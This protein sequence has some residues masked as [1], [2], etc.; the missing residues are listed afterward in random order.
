MT[1]KPLS[2]LKVL[3]L[4]SVLAGPAVGMFLAELGAEVTKVENPNT[5]GDVTRSWKLTTEDPN[6]DISAYFASVNFGKQHRF[7]DLKKDS[8]L[9]EVKKLA[10]DADIIIANYRAGQ[11]E[12]FGLDFASLK[13]VNP[14]LIYGNITGF[15]AEESR[16]AFD[17]VL[18]A[19]T[20]YMF[21]NGEPENE[22][23]K[24]PVALIDVLAAHQLKEAILLALLQREKTGNGAFVEVSLFD[25]AVSALTNQASNWLM[26]GHIPQ[27]MGSLHP[28]IAPYGEILNS[29]D[30]KQIVLAVGSNAQFTSLCEVLGLEKLAADQRFATNQHRVENRMQL[31]QELQQKASAMNCEVL[32]DSFLEKNIPAG[33]I[34]NLK[35]VFASEAAQALV[36]KDGETERVSQI[37][38]KM[39]S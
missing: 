16:P 39:R 17:V 13:K 24:M 8:E 31:Q 14:K 10:S 1:S 12:A 7:L 26:K 2:G 19:E 11:A 35:E 38:F 4:A 23:T 36:R 29:Q 32:M 22:P 34:R 21:M 28:N 20:G 33:V 27:R 25:A 37:A 30:G 5:G 9:A 15:G 6:A 3:E 18:Q